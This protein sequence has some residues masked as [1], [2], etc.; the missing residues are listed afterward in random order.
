MTH[1]SGSVAISLIL[2]SSG[3]HEL[4]AQAATP[5]L[6]WGDRILQDLRAAL[7]RVYPSSSNASSPTPAP[8]AATRSAAAAEQHYV[9][10]NGVFFLK[11]LVAVRTKFGISG[12][13]PGTR[14][15]LVSGS[16]NTLRGT[17]DGTT[18]FNVS[19]EKV[20]DNFN[21]ATVAAQNYYAAEQTAVQ[22]FNDEIAQIQ[23]E[24]KPAFEGQLQQ[25]QA[26]E[27]QR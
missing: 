10:Q 17:T 11:E 9:A 26:E 2:L 24:R 27:Q 6:T 22:A 20:T 12:L 15:R 23:Q 16:G 18:I 1:I 21:E 13:H 14:V 7:A 8:V 25:Q 4:H 5:A 3:M 19:K